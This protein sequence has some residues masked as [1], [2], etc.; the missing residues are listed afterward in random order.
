MLVALVGAGCAALPWRSALAKKVGASQMPVGEL[1]TRVRALAPR[2][3]GQ[4]EL[5]T[6]EAARQ[7]NDPR[8]RLALVDFK[9]NAVQQMELAL[10]QPDPV[11]AL[12]DTWAL[13]VQLDDRTRAPSEANTLAPSHFVGAHAHLMEMQG[14][15]EDLWRTITGASDLAPAR[16][17]VAKWAAANPL[18][19]TVTARPST[20]ALLSTLTTDGGVR[21][22]SLAGE[23]SEDVRDLTARVDLL[24]GYVP[25]AARWQAEYLLR[26]SLMDRSLLASSGM[27]FSGMLRS[28]DQLSGTAAD[29]PGLVDQQRIAAFQ[30]I[31][32]QRLE[33]Q[34]FVSQQRLEAQAFVEQQRTA[35]TADLRQER[36]ATVQDVERL[37]NDSI[38]RTFNRATTL[39]DRLLRRLLV[40]LGLLVLALLVAVI[41][42]VRA[43]RPHPETP[44]PGGRRRAPG[45]PA[46][47]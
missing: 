9:I 32:Q 29:L 30:S 5:M 14:E 11:A 6:D 18:N 38:D 37:T 17:S 40:A 35:M 15:V 47:V 2:F 16:A 46:E 1:R 10:F 12:V 24:G 41:L 21:L 4:L 31:D 45:P 26:E 13:L 43:M 36:L 39:L 27:D 23:L 42:V 8:L 7:T 19:E 20:A 28:L 25:K 22:S 34:E 33:V 44:T 3:L